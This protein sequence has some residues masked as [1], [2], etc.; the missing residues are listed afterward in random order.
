ER[1]GATGGDGRYAP[2][3]GDRYWDL[4]DAEV[5]QL[6]QR[7]DDADAAKAAGNPTPYG[8]RAIRSQA[9]AIVPRGLPPLAGAQLVRLERADVLQRAEEF[10]VLA[11]HRHKLQREKSAEEDRRCAQD[12]L[13]LDGIVA[14]ASSTFAAVR[15]VP[16]NDEGDP[17]WN[18][19][20]GGDLVFLS[21]RWSELKRLAEAI[22]TIDVRKYRQSGIS[23]L[24]KA[25]VG[26]FRDHCET[27][28]QPTS[29][30]AGPGS[31]PPPLS[32]YICH[33]A[34]R[35]VCSKAGR[36]SIS[37][38]NAINAHARRLYP[39]GDLRRQFVASHVVIV[40][41]GQSC[42]PTDAAGKVAFDLGALADEVI[43]L[44][45]A[46]TLEKPWE[47][48]FLELDPDEDVRDRFRQRSWD[49]AANQWTCHRPDGL[50]RLVDTKHQ[51]FTQY[52]LTATMRTTLRWDCAWLE[53]YFGADIV[54]DFV[55]NKCFV[56]Q[57]S[58]CLHPIWVPKG[59]KRSADGFASW[60]ALAAADD[61]DDP[62][63]LGGEVAVD[64]AA[65]S[66][67]PDPEGDELAAE[68]EPGD[69]AGTETGGSVLSDDIS[70]GGGG[71]PAH[72]V[73]L[74]PGLG[75]ISYYDTFDRKYFV[76]NCADPDHVCHLPCHTTRVSTPGHKKGQG[77]PLGWM[78]SW[79]E[80]QGGLAAARAATRHDHVHGGWRPTFEER[81]A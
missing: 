56:K 28:Q 41:L 68:S 37:M 72:I 23:E 30:L 62:D 80:R 13:S 15:D 35:C 58:A 71:L 44:L 43:F 63:D 65:E 57:K 60:A 70:D 77:R 38:L 32:D 1:S 18:G 53:V 6:M 73:V 64:A 48:T 2:G 20:G 33:A 9:L 81:R 69:S 24:H 19:V 22:A 79:L 54:G 49:E 17:P 10:R 16:H 52:E 21:Q 34:N 50:V 39:R 46:F 76:A 51:Y 3:I 74:V 67:E 26:V 11:R 5:E 78:M 59:A 25:L 31:A 66:D 29:K 47:I 55:P 27:V 7:C 36:A 8:G 75:R 45:V 42:L 40:L 12:D 61:D 14:A 4:T